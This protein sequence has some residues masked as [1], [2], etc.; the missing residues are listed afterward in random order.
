MY[1]YSSAKVLF[2]DK[3][4]DLLKIIDEYSITVPSKCI[5]VVRNN[6][7]SEREKKQVIIEQCTEYSNVIHGTI[8][9]SISVVAD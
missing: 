7:W 2:I 9:S 3:F 6:N 4:S 8:S 5:K 1:H